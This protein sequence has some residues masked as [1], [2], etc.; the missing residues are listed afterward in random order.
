MNWYRNHVWQ[1]PLALKALKLCVLLLDFYHARYTPV[2]RNVQTDL[3][4]FKYWGD[5]S[6]ESRLGKKQFQI[7][8]Y[9]DFQSTFKVT[10]VYYSETC[11]YFFLHTH[12]SQVFWNL[13]LDNLKPPENKPK[14]HH[15]S[16]RVNIILQRKHLYFRKASYVKYDT[17]LRLASSTS[18]VLRT[19]HSD[20]K[21]THTVSTD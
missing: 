3:L 9:V 5:P 11:H 12:Y 13:T 8:F 15:D 10:L 4:S 17:V 2:W 21:D 20:I 19:C 16:N 7:K 18:T 14:N 6:F 1:F